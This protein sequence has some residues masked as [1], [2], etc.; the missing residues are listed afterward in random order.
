MA[1]LFRFVHRHYKD[2]DAVSAQL[3]L[4]TWGYCTQI[5]AIIFK[6]QLGLLKQSVITIIQLGLH[7]YST[8]SSTWDIRSHAGS[9]QFGTE[10]TRQC[11]NPASLVQGASNETRMLRL[12]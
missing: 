6:L 9:T 3:L 5:I 10:N 1:L 4:Q 12:I 2:C 11:I 8:Y 7:K